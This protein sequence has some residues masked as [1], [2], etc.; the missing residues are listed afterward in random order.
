MSDVPPVT[1]PGFLEPRPPIELDA[2]TRAAFDREF[3][4]AVAAGRPVDAGRAVPAWQFLAHIV[5]TRGVLVHGSGDP[6]ITEFE[7][8]Q[9]DDTT[10]FGNQLAVYAA[11][12]ALWAMYFA[13]L[14][15][16]RHP[17]SLINAAVRFEG[18]EGVGD[19]HYFFSISRA[20]RDADAF[21]PGTVYL[22]P[23][24]GF[25]QEPAR[26]FGG[27]V[28]RSAQWASRA[29]VRPLTRI[30]VGPSDFPLLDRIRGH[31]DES[32]F[33]RARADP[34]GFPWLD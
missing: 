32:T 10:H 28:V 14:D 31:D 4:D 9:P 8:R 26:E 16:D 6:A 25:V 34:D 20:A 5:D 22:L 29:P 12:D 7:P 30:A 18:P 3:D 21:S 1:A 13:I 24:D 33:A 19:P 27:Q 17:M 15:R 23:R 2:A 11:S